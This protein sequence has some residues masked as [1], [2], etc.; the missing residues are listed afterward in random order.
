MLTEILAR[1]WD[2]LLA[3][4]QN[5]W[6]TNEPE[7]VVIPQVKKYTKCGFSGRIKP[8]TELRHTD[9]EAP[10]V[11][12]DTNK[13]M[14]NQPNHYIGNM[15]WSVKMTCNF[16]PLHR[17][18]CRTQGCQCDWISIKKSAE[19]PKTRHWKGRKNIQQ[20][21][22][23]LDMMDEE[24]EWLKINKKTMYNE[25]INWYTRLKRCYP[26]GV[27]YIKTNQG[28]WPMFVYLVAMVISIIIMNLM[29]FDQFTVLLGVVVVRSSASYGLIEA[30]SDLWNRPVSDVQ[31]KEFKEDE[32]WQTT[33]ITT[34]TTN[35]YQNY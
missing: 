32:E 26:W 30:F 7:K 22:A 23:Y 1:G 29:N 11:E 34:I 24:N 31:V 8:L 13:D 20:A 17:P 10:E 5:C 3:T 33:S 12:T 27:T 2:E 15:T 35:I 6:G 9:R 18:L 28:A 19:E 4:L 14:V 16:I 21:L 25:W